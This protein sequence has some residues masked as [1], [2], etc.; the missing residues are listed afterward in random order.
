MLQYL[1][2]DT[3]LRMSCRREE[4]LR[5]GLIV[6]AVNWVGIPDRSRRVLRNGLVSFGRVWVD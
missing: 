6:S 1:L 5:I 4:D 2:L 3:H